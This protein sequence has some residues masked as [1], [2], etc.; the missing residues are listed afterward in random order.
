MRKSI[1]YVDTEITPLILLVA[2]AKRNGAGF[3]AAAVIAATEGAD[4]MDE[5]MM[6]VGFPMRRLTTSGD[7][8]AGPIFR[9]V[10]RHF[11]GGG[12]MHGQ[13]HRPQHALRVINQ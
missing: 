3:P 7:H 11:H 2:I 8:D 10:R 9:R 12:Q 4:G 13:T 1:D 5:L 6:R